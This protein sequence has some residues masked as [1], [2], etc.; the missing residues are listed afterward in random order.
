MLFFLIGALLL[1][2]QTAYSREEFCVPIDDE[3]VID[4]AE[5]TAI[6]H[7]VSQ[8]GSLI[9]TG[10][11]RLYFCRDFFIFTSEPRDDVLGGVPYVILSVV[12]EVLWSYWP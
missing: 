5:Q 6:D 10:E 12:G 8:G 11:I 1:T 9:N 2:S 3:E 4:A 7:L